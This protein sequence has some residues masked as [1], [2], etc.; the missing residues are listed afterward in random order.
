M[1]WMYISNNKRR[2]NLK[3]EVSGFAVFFSEVQ[4]KIGPPNSILPLRGYV[5]SWV[6][7]EAV[8]V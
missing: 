2:P 7:K 8:S 5:T 1:F 3:S 4:R 6:C